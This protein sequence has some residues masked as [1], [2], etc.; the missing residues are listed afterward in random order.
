MKTIFDKATRE[1]LITRI[2]SITE[3]SPRQWGK[4]TVY[5]MLRHCTKWDEW[6]ADKK[7]NKQACI[8]RLFGKMVLKNLVKDDAPLKR[9]T[10]TLPELVIKKEGDVTAE[11]KKWVAL[12]GGYANFSNPGFVHTFFG[13]MTEEEI[14]YLAY[15]HAE[16]HLRQ[17]N[18]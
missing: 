10:P 9:S 11:K 4:M 3:N 13:K 2:N 16:H 15:K 17:F 18:C 14:G 8:G 1:E 7:Q 5:Q 6:I 12:I